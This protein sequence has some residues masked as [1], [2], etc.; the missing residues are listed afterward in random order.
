MRGECRPYWALNAEDIVRNGQLALLAR[1]VISLP[2]MKITL[3]PATTDDCPVILE[4]QI[5][6]IR[7]LCTAEYDAGQIEKWTSGL[8]ADTFRP[9]V[10]ANEFLVAE[11]DAGIVGFAEM[12]PTEGE[13]AAIYVHPRH[14]RLGLGTLLFQALERRA[15]A[16]GTKRMKLISSLTA[17]PFYQRFGFAAGPV[18]TQRLANGAEIQGVPMHRTF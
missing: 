18:T 7:E 17:V 6:S 12:N 5:A 16:D 11:G 4:T 3:R 10:E 2:V 13:I 8:T 14:A 15:R 9:G 1:L